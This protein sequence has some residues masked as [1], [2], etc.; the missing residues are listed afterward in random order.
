MA[1]TLQCIGG[2]DSVT[3]SK[4][5]VRSGTQSL[6]VDCVQ[7]RFGLAARVPDHL[8]TRPL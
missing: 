1:V 8:S 7:G 2:A 6:R 3:G 4:Y 5:L